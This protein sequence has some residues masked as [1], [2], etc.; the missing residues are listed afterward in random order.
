MHR[1]TF[2]QGSQIWHRKSMK[3]MHALISYQGNY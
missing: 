3:R 2:G 1:A